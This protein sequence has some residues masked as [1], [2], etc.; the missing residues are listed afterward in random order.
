MAVTTYHYAGPGML[1]GEDRNGTKKAYR[2]DAWGS[3]SQ[4]IDTNANITD[5]FEFDYFGNQITRTGTT[6]TPFRWRGQSGYD[7]ISSASYLDR[8]AA[9]VYSPALGIQVS[10][11]TQQIPSI[12]PPAP[13]PQKPDPVWPGHPLPWEKGYDEWLKKNR[14][15]MA[16]RSEEREKY[17]RAR[18]KEICDSMGLGS[19]PKLGIHGEWAYCCAYRPGK[20]SYRCCARLE[21]CGDSLLQEIGGLSGST[22]MNTEYSAWELGETIAERIPFVG[23]VIGLTNDLNEICEGMDAPT[24]ALIH[25]YRIGLLASLAACKDARGCSC[26]VVCYEG[27][28]GLNPITKGKFRCCNNGKSD[29]PMNQWGYDITT[30]KA[31][32]GGGVDETPTGARPGGGCC[33]P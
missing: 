15:G 25:N 6:A 27:G 28:G 20:E 29:H 16:K 12:F 8:V 14:K 32:Y 1:V 18:A 30:G 10:S 3:T 22:S 5:T 9:S 4:M 31:T 23:E 13:K 33:T 17:L 7:A 21:L 24:K 19:P 26:V 2:Q 11:Q